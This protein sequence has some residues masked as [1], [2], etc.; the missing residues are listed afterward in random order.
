[1]KL[2]HELTLKSAYEEVEKLEGLLNK[3]QEQLGFNDEFY[4]RLML[5]VSEAAT[6]AI[7]HGNKLDESKNT[8]VA[9]YRDGNKLIFVTTDEGEGFKP[10]ELPDPIAEENL[11]STSGRGVFLMKEYADE[12]FFEE[13]GR[14]LTLSFI[15]DS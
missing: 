5:A 7:V 6:N 11:L 13:D 12:V 15:L 2:L 1:M 10:D 4:A 3:L 14:K 8:V 9:A